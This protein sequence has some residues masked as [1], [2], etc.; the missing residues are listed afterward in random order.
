MNEVHAV[1]TLIDSNLDALLHAVKP[2]TV[3][4]DSPYPYQIAQD[5]ELASRGVRY[6]TGSLL[7]LRNL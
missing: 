6:T 5:D 3:S 2:Q 4:I 7:N 1:D